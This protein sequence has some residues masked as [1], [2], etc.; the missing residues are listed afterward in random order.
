MQRIGQRMENIH[1]V[2]GIEYEIQN[3]GY[4]TMKLE[5][6]I[7]GKH[8]KVQH[9]EHIAQWIEHRARATEYAPQ[10]MEH[11][12]QSTEHQAQKQRNST[13]N[14][15]HSSPYAVY[16]IFYNLDSIFCIL[17]HMLYTLCGPCPMLFVQC[18]IYS[19]FSILDSKAYP[20]QP[21]LYV[22]SCCP[23]FA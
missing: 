2:Q 16:Y 6:E 20:L 14:R 12:I 5:Y 21:T 11:R 8:E 22:L 13:L 17:Y 1:K 19:G 23:M 4:K 9:T 18:F 7:Q 15:L 10:I 3:T